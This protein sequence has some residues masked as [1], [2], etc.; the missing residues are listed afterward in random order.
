MQLN[1]YRYM[2]QKYYEVRVARM[3]VVCTHP[4]NQGTA[5]VD[6]VPRLEDLTNR[7]M[8]A[9]RATLVA[10][11]L[12]AGLDTP[13]DDQE[14]DVHIAAEAEFASQDL[15]EAMD[16][17]VGSPPPPSADDTRAHAKGLTEHTRL[18]HGSSSSSSGVSHPAPVAGHG[19]SSSSAAPA[20][21][22]AGPGT[23]S[24]SA[25]PNVP[26][27]VTAIVADEPEDE[28]SVLALTRGVVPEDGPS[29]VAGLDRVRRR[30][31]LPGAANTMQA[32]DDMFDEYDVINAELLESVPKQTHDEQWGILAHVDRLRTFV[33]SRHADW[34]DFQ[35]R[36]AVAA[37]AVYRM[38]MIDMFI[39]E[40]VML[41]WIM[42]GE[43]YIRAHAGH[44]Y[45]YHAT[46]AFQAYKGIPPEATFGRVKDFLLVLEGIFRRLPADTTRE[47]GQLLQAIS[48]LMVQHD[49]YRQFNRKCMDV[50][51]YAT[52]GGRTAGTA[53]G[54]GDDDDAPGNWP[55]LT[56]KALS[57][58]GMHLQKEL[59]EEKIFAYLI[60]W[61]DTPKL[62]RPGCACDDTVVVYND[63]VRDCPAVVGHIDASP[64][65]HIYLCIPH[66]LLDPVELGAKSRLRKIFQA[67]LLGEH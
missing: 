28:Y 63:A 50:A 18:S 12:G 41:L 13:E 3:A 56:A 11:P 24:S 54:E 45:I 4:D 40:H 9:R 67:D 25:A 8:A 2:L 42:E 58:V 62:Q 49:D 23:S 46:G 14:M 33:R 51:I 32:F 15:R 65:A 29:L 16:Q 66:P 38:R 53:G 30:R 34:P 1:I 59:L 21:S 22:T 10:D 44:C 35:Q 52:S 7:I 64:D 61:C 60:E 17:W 48:T 37:L 26:D 36:L 31:F 6:E 27:T 5:F 20:P 47:D 19:S 39:R 43:K 57:K 55:V